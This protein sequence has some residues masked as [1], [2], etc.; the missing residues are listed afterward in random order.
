LGV[1]FQAE[2]KGDFVQIKEGLETAVTDLRQVIEDTVR[3]SQALAKGDLCSAPEAEYRGELAQIKE[4][5]EMAL[6]GLNGTVAQTNVVVD[7]VVPAISQIQAISQALALTAE[8]QSAAAEEVASSLEE[9]DAQVKG[10]AESANV[11]NQLVT[12]TSNVAGVGQEKMKAMIQAMDA[13]ATSSQEIGRIIKVIDEIAFQTNLL[14]LNAAVE[15]ARAG[16]HGRGFAVV[17]QEVRNLAERSAKAARETA[18]LIADT[19]RRVEGGVGIA[20]ETAEALGEIMQSVVK[21]KDLVAEIAA[22]SDDQAQGVTQ[23]NNA[24]TQVNQGAQTSSQ[25]SEELASTA[26]ELG[27][28]AEV[29][30][31]QT[32]RFKLREGQ[33]FAGELAG[34]TPEMLRQV[35][36]LVKAQIVVGGDGGTSVTVAE[37]KEGNDKIELPLDRDERGYGEF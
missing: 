3:V 7:Q 31:A 14:A 11:A 34:M 13:I 27:Q 5:L 19:G 35:T 24:M 22:A 30:R 37:N 36:E 23:V 6:N 17:A 10:N 9:T 15:A 20:D 8:E 12:Q 28:L 29:L 2:Y 33:M 21:V 1:T 26:D 16:A 18:E 25:Q 32:A 4:G